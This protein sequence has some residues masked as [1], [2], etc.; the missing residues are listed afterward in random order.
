VVDAAK[1]ES[2]YSQWGIEIK[3]NFRNSETT[4]AVLDSHTQSGGVRSCW[5]THERTRGNC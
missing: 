5:H 2:D 1:H 3:V 4:S